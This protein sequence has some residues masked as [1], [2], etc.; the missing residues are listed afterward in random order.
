MHGMHV[1]A[2]WE[3]LT[4]VQFYKGFLLIWLDCVLSREG[5]N[6]KEPFSKPLK[7]RAF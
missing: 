4:K 7:L 2:T 5:N 6:L 1:S 3:I